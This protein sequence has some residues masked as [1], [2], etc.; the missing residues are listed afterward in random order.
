MA[1][2]IHRLIG[3]NE[4]TLQAEPG[5]QVSPV[6]IGDVGVFFQK[7]GDLFIGVQPDPLGNKDRPVLVTAQLDVVCGLQQLLGHLQ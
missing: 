5:G 3:Q 1:P 7:E 2:D 4:N 6:A